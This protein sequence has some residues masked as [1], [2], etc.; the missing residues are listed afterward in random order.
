MNPATPAQFNALARNLRRA[1]G[2]RVNGPALFRRHLDERAGFRVYTKGHHL[3]FAP[4]IVG[5]GPAQRV[6]W[7]CWRL[8]EG[9]GAVL[10]ATPEAYLDT[11]PPPPRARGVTSGAITHAA[12]LALRGEALATGKSLAVVVAD[13]LEGWEVAQRAK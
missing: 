3:R 13:I 4:C 11:D 8:Q 9:T 2:W 6:E 5:G 12:L 7:R 10:V 1:G